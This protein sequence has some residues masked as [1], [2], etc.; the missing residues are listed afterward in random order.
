MTNDTLGDGRADCQL[1]PWATATQ[2][3]LEAAQVGREC[4]RVTEPAD[5]END[6]GKEVVGQV[7]IGAEAGTIDAR[8]LVDVQAERRRLY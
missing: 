5:R 4:P 7:E 6:L 2:R 1:G 3:D 8:D